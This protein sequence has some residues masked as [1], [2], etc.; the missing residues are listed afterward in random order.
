VNVFY[1]ERELMGI[2]VGESAIV[3]F[4]KL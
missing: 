3:D 4:L 2:V 1:I